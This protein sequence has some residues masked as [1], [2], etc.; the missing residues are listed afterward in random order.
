MTNT[1]CADCGAP[2]S[3]G[4]AT[5]PQCGV[6]AIP[7]LMPPRGGRRGGG[8]LVA[9]ALLVA[10]AVAV[11]VLGAGVAAMMAAD[12]AP[13]FG[14]LAARGKETHG[15]ELLKW[16][17][18]AQLRY[19]E[20][21]GRYTSEVNELADPPP[22]TTAGEPFYTLEIS[23]ASKHELCV[24]AVPTPAAGP[25]ARTLSLDAA[26]G[27]YGSAGCGERPYMH[28][29]AFAEGSTGEEGARQMMRE[30]HGVFTKHYADHGSYPTR[31]AQVER[32]VHNTPASGKYTLALLHAGTDRVCVAAVPRATAEE[33]VPLSV[34]LDG[35]L[36]EGPTCA[37]KILE[38][39]PAASGASRPSAAGR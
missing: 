35:K 8:R 1:G 6:P 39:F 15:E 4:T 37:G 33:M 11:V 21:N 5:C 2:I 13:L 14:R 25:H 31:I 16:A 10:A 38:T 24:E 19:Y 18:V 20:D 22:P 28:A 27:I 32:G 3:P 36:Y 26:G 23:A 7:G 17:Y 34:G 30:V 9:R 29:P 12:A